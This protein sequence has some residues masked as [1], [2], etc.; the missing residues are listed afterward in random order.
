MDLIEPVINADNR[1][2]DY[3]SRSKAAVI[4]GVAYK[5]VD[6]VCTKNN[7]A[8]WQLPNHN[9]KFYSREDLYS[10]VNAAGVRD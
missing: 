10:L 7:V 5:T 4:L 3:V 6:D 8:T 9:R 2:S 1:K